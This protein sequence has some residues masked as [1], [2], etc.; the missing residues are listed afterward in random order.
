MANDAIGFIVYEKYVDP[1]AIPTIA[2]FVKVTEDKL[3]GL[4]IHES[5]GVGKFL[6]VTD[7]EGFKAD[8]NDIHNDI[9]IDTER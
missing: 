5:T 6:I 3:A 7:F 1:S 2:H 4:G 8:D 9:Y